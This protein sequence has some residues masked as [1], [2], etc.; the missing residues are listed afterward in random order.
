MPKIS[1]FLWFNDQAEA[2][3]NFY[4]SLFKNSQIG[5]VARFQGKEVEKVSGRPDGSVMTV[6]F[7]ICGMNFTAL[8]GGPVFTVNP[9]ISF[10]VNCETEAEIDGLW[11]K[12]MDGGKALM[13][14]QEYPFSKK[15][16]WVQDKF[17][18]S[19]QL[20]LT[21]TEQ[22][23]T[24]YLAF[25]GGNYGRAEEAMNLYCTIFKNSKIGD[26][27]RAGPGEPEPEGTISHATFQLDG[28]DFMILE[29]KIDHKFA[30]NEAISF[31][32]DC[33]DQNEV[34]Y[35]WEKL[36]E[37]GDPAAQQCGWLKDKF[38]VSWQV[39]PSIMGK[40]MGGPNG[41]KVTNAMLKMKKI[42]IHALE[43][44]AKS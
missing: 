34:D 16:G 25:V 19:W 26:I 33:A 39:V 22:K 32:V 7:Q 40:L 2:A 6:M 37:G 24:P 41:E 11:A 38:G 42:D 15:F 13:P 35:F 23:I 12:L 18:V 4:V 1:P 3:A 8:N 20:I 9:S 17:G 44:A 28:Q 43:E 36:S 5:F 21:E 14:L 31:V 10:A 29:S 27:H 30:F